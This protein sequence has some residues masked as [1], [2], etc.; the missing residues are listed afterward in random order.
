MA[1][2]KNRERNLN[3]KQI[4]QDEA[5]ELDDNFANTDPFKNCTQIWRN[6]VHYILFS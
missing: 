6:T 2:W 5:K 4:I 3:E 1:R